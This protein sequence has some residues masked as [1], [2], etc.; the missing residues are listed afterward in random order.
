[1]LW[2]LHFYLLGEYIG[3]NG[4]SIS[5]FAQYFEAV[6]VPDGSEVEREIL[7]DY[8]ECAAPVVA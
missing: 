7:Q 8:V 4:V 2:K 6:K 3:F 1:M 5:K